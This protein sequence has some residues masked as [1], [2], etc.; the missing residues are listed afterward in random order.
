[1]L[2]DHKVSYDVQVMFNTIVSGRGI[3]VGSGKPL[4]LATSP[5]PTTC[6][7]APAR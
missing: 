6:S 1:M 7:R 4:S 5:W 3:T 2:T